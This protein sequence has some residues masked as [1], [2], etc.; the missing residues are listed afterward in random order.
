[1]KNSML[2]LLLV[3][4]AVRCGQVPKEEN[5]GSDVIGL[6]AALQPKTDSVLFIVSSRHYYGDSKINAANHF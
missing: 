5:L 1:M 3:F 2:L 6:N 4:L